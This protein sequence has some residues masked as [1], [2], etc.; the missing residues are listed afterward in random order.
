MKPLLILSLHIL[1]QTYADMAFGIL[2]YSPQMPTV[3][4]G[5]L[6]LPDKWQVSVSCTIIFFYII[7]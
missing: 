7:A 4:V 6:S 1:G 5:F 3:L 2:I